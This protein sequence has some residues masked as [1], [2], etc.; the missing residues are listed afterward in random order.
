MPQGL[1]QLPFLLASH[2]VRPGFEPRMSQQDFLL[3]VRKQCVLQLLDAD[4]RL[5]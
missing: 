4:A 3:C 1:W 5:A 2:Q